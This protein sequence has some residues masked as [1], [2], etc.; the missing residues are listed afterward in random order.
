[1]AIV[2]RKD[3]VGYSITI[4]VADRKFRFIQQKRILA[5][6]HIQRIKKFLSQGPI[7]LLQINA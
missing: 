4:Y 6:R 7:S 2:P 1:M 3:D 5:I